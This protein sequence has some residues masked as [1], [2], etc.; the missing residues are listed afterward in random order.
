[1]KLYSYIVKSDTGLAPNPFWGKLTLNVCKPDIRRT[2]S[3]GN[4]VIGTG[5]KNVKSKSGKIIDYSGKLV[6]AMKVTS[7][8][9]MKE[10]DDYCNQELKKKIPFPDK[11]DW[12]RVLG[13]CI[14]DFSTGTV[15]RLRKLLHNENDKD[16][17]LGG[18]IHFSQTTFI[19]SEAR[20]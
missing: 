11:K 13:D 10:Y 7:K 5:S 2:A 4:W 14:Y 8:M 12:R 3:E 18:K 17:D 1:M 15:P 16:T 6:Y 19:I 20:Q 9:S